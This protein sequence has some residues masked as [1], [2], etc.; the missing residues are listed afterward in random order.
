[1]TWGLDKSK[2]LQEECIL[3]LGLEEFL[4]IEFQ[5][6]EHAIFLKITKH[7]HTK[8]HIKVSRNNKQQS[9]I[10]KIS[11]IKI[12]INSVPKKYAYYVVLK[13]TESKIWFRDC[14]K[15]SKNQVEI[16]KL[17]NMINEI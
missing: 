11:N 8:S 4:W 3:K 7:I 10:Q 15:L 16:L 5:K 2:I 1:M 17:E 12:I 14:Q 6:E 13:E 9:H